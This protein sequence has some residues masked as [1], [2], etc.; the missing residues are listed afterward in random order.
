MSLHSAQQLV[1]GFHPQ[2]SVVVETSPT[3]L[4]SDGGLLL[5]R[6]FDEQIALT[7]RFAAALHDRRSPG[8]EHSL[9][10]LVRQRISGLLAD[11]EDQ[12]D[13]DRLRSDPVFQL[14]ADRRPDEP[15]L[16]SQPTLSR[17]ENAVTIADLW[18]LR[19]DLVAQF[20]DSFATPPVRLTRDVD[21]FDDPTHGGQQLIFFHGHYDQCQDLP[22][23]V[24]WA[25]TDQV[26]LVRLRHGTCA[27]CLG[28]DDDLRFLVARLRQRW[29]EVAIH[30]RGDS[31][32]GV[33]VM[34]QVCED[35]GVT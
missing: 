10:S 35:L 20:L 22:L 28:A 26:L 25:E 7:G 30:V 23:T 24:T 27:A 6:E 2:R 15:D 11:D 13:H 21:A 17:F 16:A 32:F 5:V 34:Y 8:T 12:N 33:P 19:E 29:P 4:S 1:L 18:R 31:G 9:L 14:L 3:Q